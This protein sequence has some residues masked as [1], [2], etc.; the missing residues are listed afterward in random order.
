VSSSSR[1]APERATVSIDGGEMTGTAE[2][3]VGLTVTGSVGEEVVEATA[4]L[5]GTTSSTDETERAT[6]VTVTAVVSEPTDVLIG[7]V[8]SVLTGLDLMV[9]QDRGDERATGMGRL[10]TVTA[11]AVTGP[12]YGSSK[13][14]VLF[15]Q[16]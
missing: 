8:L 3:A 5:T 9:V 16:W 6:E 12:E 10:L 11:R 1:D 7:G 14:G 15:N 2:R 13:S 4:E